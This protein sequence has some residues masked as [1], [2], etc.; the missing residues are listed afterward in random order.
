MNKR[1]CI[2]EGSKD[3]LEKIMIAWHDE[4]LQQDGPDADFVKKGRT[5]VS[6]KS[7]QKTLA[8]QV[9]QTRVAAE[10][11]KSL[12]VMSRAMRKE[13]RDKQKAMDAEYLLNRSMCVYV[14]VCVCMC[15]CVNMCV[16]VLYVL[17]RQ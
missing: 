14:C 16:C 13:A 15:V 10:A 7:P 6:C 4:H 8:A 2:V 12:E 3:V 9:R 1:R 11:A 17:V 5:F